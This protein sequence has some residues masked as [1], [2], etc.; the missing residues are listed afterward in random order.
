MPLGIVSNTDYEKD[1]NPSKNISQP[2]EIREG[3]VENSSE[4][5]SSDKPEEITGGL[6]TIAATGRGLGNNGVPPSIRKIVGDSAIEEGSAAAQAIGKFLGLSKS[7]VSAYARGATSTATY[8]KPDADLESH[9]LN[10][11]RKI[12]KKASGKLF[13]SLNVIDDDSLAKLDAL[14]ASTVAKNMAA[15]IKHMEPEQRN[16]PTINGP[17]ITFYAPHIV[18]EE[19]FDVIN[20]NE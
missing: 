11:R 1:L 17:V 10:T 6:E 3:E 19:Q 2:E 14:Q 15:I 7:S 20:V 5:N 12:S 9:L 18:A 4:S 16:G 13:K 8:N